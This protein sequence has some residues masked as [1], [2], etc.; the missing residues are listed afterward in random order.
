MHTLSLSLEGEE[1][2]KGEGEAESLE[3]GDVTEIGK[4]QSS[5]QFF[6]EYRLWPA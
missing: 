4:T 5:P 3:D 1:K 2:G 6:R